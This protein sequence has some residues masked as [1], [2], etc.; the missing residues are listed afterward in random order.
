MMTDFDAD[1]PVKPLRKNGRTFWTTDR[2]ILLSGFAL[3]V[4]A[5]F[6][7]WYIFFNE[8]KFGINVAITTMKREQPELA[9]RAI[10][11]ASPNGFSDK[12][13]NVVL[14]PFGDQL[15]T[16]T[17]PDRSNSARSDA[18]AD[19]EQPFPGTVNAFR[20]LHV[21]NG[22]AM[23]EDANG[24]YIVGPGGLLP[25]RSKLESLEDRSGTWVLV[26]DQG[27]EY[28]QNGRR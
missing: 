12:D 21:S 23:I 26:T 9:G 15:I 28:D 20:V 25:D 17:I 10:V 13:D 6:Y 16:G 2:V 4:S 1:E 11:S 19:E 27:V 8:D 7:P 22:K 18:K 5:A 24:V 14:P 3:A